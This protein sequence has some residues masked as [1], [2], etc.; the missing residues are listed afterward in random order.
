VS[1]AHAGSEDERLPH[2]PYS[3]L[4]HGRRIDL[5]DA[6]PMAAPLAIYVE[7]TNVCN[8]RCT[9]C[10]ESFHDYKHRSG[11]LHRLDL[12]AF[13]TI[14]DQIAALGKLKV[15]HFYM[16]GEPFLNR[17]LPEFVRIAVRKQ[18]ADRTCITTNATVMDPSTVERILDSGLDYL[19]VSVYG[20]T[21]DTF[22]RRTG[23]TTKLSRVIANVTALKVARDSRGS[24][25]PF[26]YA[27][28]IDTRDLAENDLFL[29]TF[30]AISDEV[31]IEPVMNWNDPIEGNLAQVS[32]VQL[33]S[34]NYFQ[35]R[36]KACPFPF[37][38]LVVHS[39]LRVSVCC[40]DWAKEAVVGD[41]KTESLTQI[42][43]GERLRAFRLA[44]LRGEREHIGA[45]ARC[46]YLFTAPDTV[47]ALSPE[48]YLA[49]CSEGG[50]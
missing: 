49:R 45:C 47:D 33:L 7:P 26:I 12:A 20:A 16:M 15:L 18:L 4:R 22:A 11:G 6:S 39:D 2:Q 30:A 14:A 42:W 32:N 24:C 37:Y 3:E 25:R 41:L 1:S 5:V 46:T 31:A 50:Q 21:D 29:T 19:R 38:T 23:V 28:M 8:F 35:H 13:V 40:V 10:P 9:Y 36:K 48:V 43:S 27:K 44:H 17:E 34:G